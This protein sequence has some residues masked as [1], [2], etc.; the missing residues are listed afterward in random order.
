MFSDLSGYTAMNE[1]L[2]PEEVERIMSR[3]KSDAVGIVEKHG[4]IVNQFA[5]DEVLA[6]FG[7]PTAHEDDP[8]RAVRAALEVHSL[9]RGLS[10]EVED[11]IGRPL[12]MHTGINT[13]LVVTHLRDDRDGRYGI[14]GDAVNLAARIVNLAGADEILVSAETH[15]PIAPFFRTEE[16]EPVAVKGKALPVISYRI[17]G[18]SQVK[19]RFEA[20]E[21][22]GFTPYIG[23]E[24][25]L[26]A[27]QAELEKAIA[28][29]GRLVNVVGE[30]GLGKTRLLYEFRHSLHREKITVLQGRC[31]AEGGA[32]PYL[33]FTDALRRGLDLQDD[34][35]A[36]QRQE[37]TVAGVKAIDPELEQYLPFYLHL[38][39]IP[40]E[41][42]AL[43]PDLTGE[44]LRAKLQMALAAIVIRN[45]ERQPMVLILED[46]H[47]ADGGS[48][49]ALNYLIGL[50]GA[51]PLL[52]VLSHRPD[53]KGAW[54]G[55]T[56]HTS[57]PLTALTA[58]RSAAIAGAV[59]GAERLP[60]G[61]GELIHERTG[62]NPFFIE[63]MCRHLLE[64]GTVLVNDGQAA[65]T[66]S[67]ET[68]SLPNTVQAV[69]RS[70]LDRLDEGHREVLRVASVIGRE[71]GGGVLERAHG[72][73]VQLGPVLE[74]LKGQDLVQQVRVLPEGTYLFRHILT[75]V[76]V[77]ETLLH[78]R[79]RA[80]H[81]LVGRAL[82][83]LYAE[84]LEEHYEA[85]AHQFQ[86]SDDA[87]KAIHYLELAGDKA[88]GYFSLVEARKL[89]K[90]ALDLVDALPSE[91]RPDGQRI[92][93]SLKWVSVSFYSPSAEH[94][95]TL[96]TSLKYAERLGDPV[97]K[98]RIT[99]W[100]G[101]MFYYLGNFAKARPF[102]ESC[103]KSAEKF[104]DEEIYGLSYNIMGRMFLFDGEA[105]KGIAYLEKGIPMMERLNNKVEVGHSAGYLGMM[106]GFVGDFEN[107][108][109]N[110]RTALSLAAEGSDV[111]RQA[112]TLAYE[113][114]VHVFRGDWGKCIATSDRCIELSGSKIGNSMMEAIATAVKGH[115]I[116]MLG[117]QKQ[118]EE[119]TRKGI[120]SIESIG[121]KISL[122][123][124]YSQLAEMLCLIGKADEGEAFAAQALDLAPYGERWGASVA[125]LALAMAAGK[126]KRPAWK[127]VDQNMRESFR[128]AEAMHAQPFTA[129]S[130]FRYA[131]LLQQ[132]G[133]LAAAREQIAKA[134][135]LFRDMGMTWWLGQAEKLKAEVGKG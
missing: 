59:L 53:Y 125:Y 20:A 63:E 99:Y 13:G 15:R 12:R 25:E 74:A 56:R 100:L 77:Y 9:A 57:L 26:A 116:F 108:A 38:L 1:K 6:L 124:W 91:E 109:K 11:R 122:S 135:A 84:R 126:R 112:A 68:L 43:P 33:P 134:S 92:A 36:E 58:E 102:F 97:Q 94:V 76:V 8:R 50:I 129:V 79:R 62:G 128:Q 118:G 89:Y 28:G 111:N 110:F 81:G 31:Q 71:F 27:L 113:A 4:G 52:V 54:S 21:A 107:G 44:A 45:A 37:K 106:Y 7:I 42:H 90:G 67:L 75:Q 40:S 87:E 121:A 46:W 48:E 17:L 117:D 114:G 24:S 23:R 16:L 93:L 14:T 66:R 22:R 41:Q 69:I 39:S 104:D 2:D 115:A 85:L 130:H 78:R 47:W 5:G 55:A 73:G 82:E 83:A 18:E 133:D 119:L 105:A 70:R 88:A 131:E 101:R 3:L 132:K 120:R 34:E 61:L 32:T 86:N 123:M 80:L 127:K 29:Q 96:M 35:T 98:V 64:D 65:I 10:S 72:G 49:A 103:L 19:T 51:H 30:A 95:E 60:E